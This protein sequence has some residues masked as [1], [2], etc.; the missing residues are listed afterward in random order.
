M[1]G[2]DIRVHGDS[3][4]SSLAGQGRVASVLEAEAVRAIDQGFPPPQK[5]LLSPRHS[6]RILSTFECIQLVTTWEREWEAGVW[7]K[8]WRRKRVSLDPG[9]T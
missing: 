2:S 3:A 5:H 4:R 8:G 7:E 9:G 1:P 6:L